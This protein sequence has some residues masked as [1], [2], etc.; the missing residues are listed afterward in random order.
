MSFPVCFSSPIMVTD[1][2]RY[3]IV[4][5]PLPRFHQGE[6]QGK[7]RQFSILLGQASHNYPGVQVGT[8]VHGSEL[9]AINQSAALKVKMMWKRTPDQDVPLDGGPLEKTNNFNYLDSM[10][11]VTSQRSETGLI[12]PALKSLACNIA[13]SRRVKYR[14]VKGVGS[15]R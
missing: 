6:G 3:A 15:F 12:L 1:G 2:L 7:W 10:F 9:E 11:V 5:L 13:F 4:T 8:N 14:R